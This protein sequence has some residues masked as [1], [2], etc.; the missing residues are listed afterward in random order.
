MGA[1]HVMWG[2]AGHVVRV[3][4][5]CSGS[6]V[7][8]RCSLLSL[9]AGV[10]TSEKALKGDNPNKAARP[11]LCG[12]SSLRALECRACVYLRPDRAR[13]LCLPLLPPRLS[14]PLASNKC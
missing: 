13:P 8:R 7:L 3:A 10:E 6:Q 1:K 2:V 9:S 12:A 14:M 4:E 11:R 5:R